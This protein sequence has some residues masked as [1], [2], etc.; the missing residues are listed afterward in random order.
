MSMSNIEKIVKGIRRNTHRKFSTEEKVRI[1][2]R[3]SR[4]RVQSLSCV[5]RKASIRTC[6]TAGAR[7]ILK[8]QTSS[9][10]ISGSNDTAT[11]A[12]RHAIAPP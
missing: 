4:E 7:A 12:Y 9:A 10:S 5:P 2:L 11:F 8:S 1:V 6:I 3:A